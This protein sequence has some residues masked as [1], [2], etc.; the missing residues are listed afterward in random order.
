MENKKQ[1]L[2]FKEFKMIGE[3]DEGIGLR[4]CIYQLIE[5]VE[6]LV[7]LHSFK[8]KKSVTGIETTIG[9]IFV[10]IHFILNCKP[11]DRKRDGVMWT[12]LYVGMGLLGWYFRVHLAKC[13]DPTRDIEDRKRAFLQ[14]T[15]VS[16]IFAEFIK[17]EV[18]EEDMLLFDQKWAHAPELE[19]E[20]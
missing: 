14:W 15:H 12:A 2:E 8:S 20:V 6:D 5:E 11:K 9:W 18:T 3:T 7:S 1:S 13:C 19:G 4:E 17:P 10:F 16:E